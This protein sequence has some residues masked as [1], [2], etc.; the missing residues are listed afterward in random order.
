MSPKD[1]VASEIG[2]NNSIFIVTLRDCD[3]LVGMG[4]IIGDKG[5]FYHIVDTAVA[6]SYQGK[7]LGKLIMSEINT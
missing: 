2:L 6:P 1:E 4:R 5:C 3:K 7:G